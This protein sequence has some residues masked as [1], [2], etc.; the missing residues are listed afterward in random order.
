MLDAGELHHG[1][2][3]RKIERQFDMVEFLVNDTLLPV[4]AA[5]HRHNALLPSP[6][7]PHP[8]AVCVHRRCWLCCLAWAAPLS[9]IDLS[10]WLLA[11]FGT[12]Q[13]SIVPL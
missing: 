7:V 9:L 1:L 10:S 8:G 4:R 3:M 2:K 12:V 13:S 6:A 11:L 5:W